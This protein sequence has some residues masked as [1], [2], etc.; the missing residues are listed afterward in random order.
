MQWVVPDPPPKAPTPEALRSI[1]TAIE[2]QPNLPALP[3]FR[4][5]MMMR[6]GRHDDAITD[7]AAAMAMDPRGPDYPAQ[8][9]TCHLRARRPEAALEFCDGRVPMVPIRHGAYSAAGHCCVW[10]A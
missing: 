4:A 3:A 2:A 10:A 5:G 1:S 7:F 9:A 8:I 6:L